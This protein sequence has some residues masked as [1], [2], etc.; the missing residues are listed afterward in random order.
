M[1]HQRG[2]VLAPD[3][4]YKTVLGDAEA[5]RIRSGIAID[6]RE[7][8][9]LQ[10]IVDR[11]RALVLDVL[12]GAADRGLVERDL[13]QALR[14]LI[15]LRLAGHLGVNRIA[16]ARAWASS[17]SALP[18]AIAAGPSL[19][20]ASASSRRIEVRFMKSSTPKPDEKRAERAV[21]STWLEPAT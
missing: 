12:A 1:R 20:S 9:V 11:D 3:V 21:G 10:E 17:P 19:R 4:E 5:Q 14:R 2:V 7:G 13:D 8:I 16:T 18:S 15:A 6:E